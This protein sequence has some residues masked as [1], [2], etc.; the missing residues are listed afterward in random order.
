MLNTCTYQHIR[1]PD[2]VTGIFHWH[3]PSGR[4][5]ALG[6]TSLKQ[7][8]EP[9]IFPGGQRRPVRRA[10]NL[11]TFMCRLSRNL[12]SSTFC[13]PKGLSRPLQGLLY[14][15]KH[16][17]AQNYFKISCRLWQRHPIVLWGHIRHNLHLLIACV[18]TKMFYYAQQSSGSPIGVEQAM[19]KCT[20]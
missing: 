18:P 15:H 12:G 5:M 6:S 1:V 4:S 13:N 14:L 8:W 2:G 7:K 16:I 3:N 10:D 11:T 17:H 9:G 20:D 19:L